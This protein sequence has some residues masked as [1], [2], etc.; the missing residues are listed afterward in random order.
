MSGLEPL[1]IYIAGALLLTITAS[2][3]LLQELISLVHLYKKLIAAVRAP[4]PPSPPP[5]DN[6]GRSSRGG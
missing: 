1:I 5:G 4:S 6:D 2:R 3:F